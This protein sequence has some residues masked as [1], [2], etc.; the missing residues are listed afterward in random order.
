MAP[1]ILFASLVVSMLLSAFLWTAYLGYQSNLA[2][3]QAVD[4]LSDLLTGGALLW[5]LHVSQLP[6]DDDHPFGHHSA[7][8]I[9]ALVVAVLVGVMAVEVGLEAVDTLRTH[10][11]AEL[12]GLLAVVLG[13]KVVAK[14]LLLLFA[15]PRA[16]EGSVLQAF[17]VDARNDVLI[18]VVSLVGLAV[19]RYGARPSLDAW[20]AIPLAMW[21]FY[22]GIHL[23]I[24]NLRLL[25]G[26]APPIERRETLAAIAA[27]VALVR[28]VAALK[29]RHHGNHLHVWIEIHVDPELS[30]GSAHDVGEAVEQRLLQE[31]D[32]ASVT[33]HV[34]A[35]LRGAR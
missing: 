31:P 10:S 1:R 28:H 12:P 35:D 19:A 14:G 34:D 5:A 23:G 3:A 6:P 16:G 2:L 4:S 20:L 27:K 15:G 26:V 22:S 32:V 24:E 9:A 33:A 21:I 8:P 13:A 7:E 17:R 11:H 18:G 30:V 29:A 25:M